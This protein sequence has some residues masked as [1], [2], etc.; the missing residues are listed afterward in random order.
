M[1]ILDF[2]TFPNPGTN[3]LLW[4]RIIIHDPETTIIPCLHFF[5]AHS[6]N[7]PLNTLGTTRLIRNSEVYLSTADWLLKL[8]RSMGDNISDSFRWLDNSRLL[9]HCSHLCTHHLLMTCFLSFSGDESCSKYSEFVESQNQL[10]KD[11]LKQ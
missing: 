5:S 1:Y 11:Y 6:I 9:S 7:V 3:D 4:A 8:R 2:Q 10:S